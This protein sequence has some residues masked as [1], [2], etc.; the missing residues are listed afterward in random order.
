MQLD[1]PNNWQTEPS[2]NVSPHKRA[3]TATVYDATQ[4]VV[5]CFSYSPSSEGLQQHI[6]CMAFCILFINSKQTGALNSV[7]VLVF[8]QA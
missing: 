8:L 6:S 3:L 1:F 4:A 5:V 7:L 2:S